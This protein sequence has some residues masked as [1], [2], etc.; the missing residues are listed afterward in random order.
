VER[1]FADVRKRHKLARIVTGVD[2]QT[3]VRIPAVKLSP[4]WNQEFADITFI[5]PIGYPHV[6]PDCFYTESVLRLASGQEP[7]NS[8]VQAVFD[9]QYRWFS[10]HVKSWS[11]KTDTLDAYARFCERRLRDVR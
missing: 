10:W 7:A 9:G 4:G 11:P 6:A 2:G 8:N 3:V 5:V 1:Q